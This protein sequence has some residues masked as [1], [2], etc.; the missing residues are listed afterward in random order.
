MS[1]QERRISISAK[2]VILSE[3]RLLTVVKEAEGGQRT[4][5]LPGGSQEFGETLETALQRE[6]LEEIGTEVEVQRL[7]FVREYIGA[8]HEHADADAD[9]HIVDVMF[10]SVAPDDYVP[11]SGLEPDTG[12]EG[13]V[14]L[15]IDE[16]DQYPFFPQALKAALLSLESQSVYL[17][18]VN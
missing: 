13:V 5:I 16:L 18:D 10:L 6:C 3:D 9:L 7:L 15:P 17:G 1:E 2:A 4:Y 12:Q 14:W 11:Q 8:N